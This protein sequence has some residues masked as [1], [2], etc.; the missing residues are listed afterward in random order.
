MIRMFSPSAVARKRVLLR[1][2]FNVPIRSRHVLDEYDIARA[3]P[4]VRALI[5]FGARVV[6]LSHHSA[7]RQSLVAL[8]PVLSRRLGRPVSFLR[9]PFTPRARALIRRAR[10]GRV[11]LCENVRFWPGEQA[12]RPGFAKRLAALGEVFVNEAFGELH[13][14]HASIVGLPRFLPSFAGPLVAREIMLLDRF[15]LRPKRPLVLV[16]GGAKTET[17]LPLLKRFLRRA[18]RVVVG[19]AVANT[20]L[21]ARGL[22]V[23]RSLAPSTRVTGLRSIARSPR[24]L[25][26]VDAVVAPFG[27]PGSRR[28]SAVVSEVRPGEAIYDIGL[29]TR[30]LFSRALAGAGSVI[31]NGPMG[32]TEK[33][34]YEHG[35][36]AVARALA[37]IGR[38]VLVGGGDTVA[39]LNRHKLLQRFPWVSTGGGAMLAYLAGQKL[40][41]LEALKKHQ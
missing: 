29:Q 5:R 21:R 36:R 18:D 25:L 13:R 1:V 3:L 2:D 35:T 10:A 32:F 23:G 4:T 27:R 19:G 12:N 6:L 7:P 14:P 33:R 30:R 40:P 39:F 26:P 41:G 31:W 22:S 34:S 24:V 16:I 9:N 37:K 28:R 15:R 11:F 38:R 8:T 20:L 17:K